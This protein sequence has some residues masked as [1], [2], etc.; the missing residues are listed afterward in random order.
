[1]KYFIVAILI[2]MLSSCGFVRIDIEKD[3]SSATAMTLFKEIHWGRYSSEN[4]KIKALGPSG[5]I[6]SE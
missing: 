4:N 3:R 5:Y 2:L 6:E 1:M